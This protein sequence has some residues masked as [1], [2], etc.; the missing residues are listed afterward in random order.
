MRLPRKAGAE[1]VAAAER[2]RAVVEEYGFAR[3]EGALGH[4]AAATLRSQLLDS[5]ALG[6]LPTTFVNEPA[7][8]THALLGGGL[9]THAASTTSAPAAALASSLRELGVASVAGRVAGLFDD[10]APPTL[11]QL[12]AA[13]VDDAAPASASACALTE[14]ATIVVGPGAAGQDPHPDSQVYGRRQGREALCSV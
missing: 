3:V 8:R 10:G 7:R 13:V 11:A 4:A 9:F 1:A 6:Q 5:A 12:L 2:V 14:L